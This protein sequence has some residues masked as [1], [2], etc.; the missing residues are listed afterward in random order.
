MKQLLFLVR[1]TAAAMCFAGCRTQTTVFPSRWKVTIEKGDALS[2]V[3]ENGRGEM[4]AVP[5]DQVAEIPRCRAT[6]VLKYPCCVVL[7]TVDGT[8]FSI[9]GPD[10]TPEVGSFVGT[11]QVRMTYVFPDAFMEYQKRRDRRPNQ[12]PEDTARKLAE[13]QH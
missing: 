7:R 3:F 1:C 13:P 8:P 12:V 11:L 2:C 9:G 10:A 6:V 5:H 4:F